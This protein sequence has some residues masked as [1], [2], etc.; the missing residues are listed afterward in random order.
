[1]LNLQKGS[2]LN[3]AKNGGLTFVSVGLGWSPRKFATQTDFDLDASAFVLEEDGSAFGK[4]ITLP[5]ADEGWLCFYNQPRLPGDALVHS[6]D[7]RTGSGAGDDET[8]QIDFSKLPTQASRVAII[9]TIHEGAQRR[10]NFGQ[11]EEAYAK[12]YDKDGTAVAEFKLSEDE[13]TATAV[14]M[15]FVEFKKNSAGEW[16][17]SA[18]GEGFNHALSDFCKAFKVPGFI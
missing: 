15:M 16:V 7:N 3:L 4:V 5:T 2:K 13:E 12:V 10:Q 1:M 18:V 9:V 14:S 8:I 17:M 11:V 6:G